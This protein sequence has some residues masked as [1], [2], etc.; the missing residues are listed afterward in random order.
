MKKSIVYIITSAMLLC[1]L[2]TGCST[3][4][5]AVTARRTTKKEQTRKPAPKPSKP[6]TANTIKWPTTS[7]SPAADKL[8]TEARSWLGTPY[9]YG[10]NTTDGV[11][12]SG[13]VLQVYQRALNIKLPRNSAKQQEFCI[14][15]NR[16][17]LTA[18]DLVFFSSTGK[19]EVAHVG[20]YIGDRNF[21]HSSTSKGVIVS[22]LDQK[23]YAD[24]FHSFGRIEKFGTIAAPK[25]PA[26]TAPATT[27][28]NPP[29]KP[30]T[31]K[32][33]IVTPLPSTAAAMS[34]DRQKAL[35]SIFSTP[36]PPLN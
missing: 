5:K 9:L 36:A 15:V 19:S 6:K 24:N 18:G 16:D 32:T 14:P 23:Y 8:L 17:Q 3:S 33:E 29:E 25:I 4:N 34:D 12:C 21:I 31:I 11:D 10:G 7:L 20:I 27:K 35:Q 30:R 13:F 28:V 22:S 1:L 26:Q 2:A